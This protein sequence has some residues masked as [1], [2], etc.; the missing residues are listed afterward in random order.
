[1][2]L[3]PAKTVRISPQL[4]GGMGLEAQ[5]VNHAFDGKL[6]AGYCM[7]HSERAVDHVAGGKDA[8]H[9]GHAVLIDRQQAAMVSLQTTRR[10]H[11]LVLGH[12]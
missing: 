7:D 1:M 5:V 8:R 3:L 6:G 4:M 12:L 10:K 2:R 9:G 11:K